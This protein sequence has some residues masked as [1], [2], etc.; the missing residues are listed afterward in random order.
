MPT[1]DASNLFV[2]VLN[3]ELPLS[4]VALTPN[5]ATVAELSHAFQARTLSPVDAVDAD[6]DAVG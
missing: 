3:F 1:H 4:D 2:T 5:A 6:E